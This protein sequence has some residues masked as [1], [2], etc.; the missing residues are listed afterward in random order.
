MSHGYT[1]QK[2][3]KLKYKGYTAGSHGTI[4][5]MHVTVEPP[6]RYSV[7]ANSII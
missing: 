7:A 6:I 3:T 4:A 1:P 5:S 2:H